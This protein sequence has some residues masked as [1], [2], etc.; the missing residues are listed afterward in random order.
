MALYSIAA[1]RILIE[2]FINLFAQIHST[3][4]AANTAA[5][6]RKMAECPPSSG[7]RHRT[8]L[9]PGCDYQYQH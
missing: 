6:P 9:E 4:I 3:T 2:V 5:N 7:A 1:R 8:S